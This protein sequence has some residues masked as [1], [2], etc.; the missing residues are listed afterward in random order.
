MSTN[1]IESGICITIVDEQSRDTDSANNSHIDGSLSTPDPDSKDATSQDVVELSDSQSSTDGA[2]YNHLLLSSIH[3]N[4]VCGTY[5]SLLKP[6]DDCTDTPNS[7]LHSP[8]GYN[9]SVAVLPQWNEANLDV[10]QQLSL[11]VAEDTTNHQ[12]VAK[13]M[14]WPSDKNSSY[15]NDW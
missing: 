4:D 3:A 5:P 9:S 8:D 6:A 13:P 10:L 11:S 1:I 2:E 12:L 7:A 14:S 15:F